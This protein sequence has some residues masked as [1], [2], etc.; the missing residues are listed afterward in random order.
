MTQFVRENPEHVS[1]VSMVFKVDDDLDLRR[2]NAP[3]TSIEVGILILGG[4]RRQE[5][6]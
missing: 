4:G 1:D 6:E 2:Y 3:T 5:D